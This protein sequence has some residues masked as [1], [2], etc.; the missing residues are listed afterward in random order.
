M[1]GA[2]RY[3]W[4]YRILSQAA[5]RRL[6]LAGFGRSHTCA[7]KAACAS[8][9]GASTVQSQYPQRAMARNLPAYSKRSRCS[10]AVGFFTASVCLARPTTHVRGAA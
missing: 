3:R 8:S 10:S 4:H 6:R 2:W 7:S 9:T 5:T 1:S